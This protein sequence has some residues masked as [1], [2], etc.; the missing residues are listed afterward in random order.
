MLNNIL[1]SEK[2]STVVRLIPADILS[3]LKKF[4]FRPEASE[5]KADEERSEIEEVKPLRKKK[6]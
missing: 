5:I 1:N 4:E 3:R 6:K 2:G